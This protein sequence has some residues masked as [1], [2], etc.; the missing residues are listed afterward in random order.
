ML[1]DFIRTNRDELISRTRAKVSSRPWPSVSTIELE[2]GIAL[3]LAR[4]TRTTCLA[5]AA[6]STSSS[7]L[8]PPSAR[9]N[10]GRTRSTRS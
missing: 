6:S 2:D 3:F 9:L 4:S 8:C 7:P 1:H 10:N 5:R